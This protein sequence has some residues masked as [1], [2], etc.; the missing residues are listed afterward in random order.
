MNR[1][2]SVFFARGLINPLDDIRPDSRVSHLELL[3]LLAEEF[4][5]TKH[6]VKHLIRCICRSAAY[7]RS[8]HTLPKNKDDDEF[9]SHVALKVIPP[10]ALFAT[11]AMVTDNHVRSPREDRGGKKGAA[12]DGLGFYDTREYDESPAEYTYGVPQLLRLMNTQLPPACDTVAQ[13]LPKLGSQEKAIEH[14]YLLALSRYPN[15]TETTRM[16]AFI[17]KHPDPVKGYSSA[18]WVLLHTA[19]FFNNH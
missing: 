1:F 15:P 18:L 9:Y 5:S 10:R 12:S 14:L 17:A 13:G 7:Q 8:S 16:A 3:E 2:W 19:E 4:I 6:D 11:L